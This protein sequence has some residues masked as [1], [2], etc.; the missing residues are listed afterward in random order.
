MGKLTGCG[1]SAY[2]VLALWAATAIALQA[3]T[4][5]TLFDFGGLDGANPYSALVQG[6]GGNLYGTTVGGGAYRV[7]GGGGTIFKITPSGTLTTLYNFCA[8]SGCTDGQGPAAGLVLATN[9]DFYGTTAHGGTNTACQAAYESC[10]TIFEITPAGALTTLYNFCSQGSYPNCTDGWSPVAGLF[11]AANGDL[12]GT[13]EFG[14][15]LCGVNPGYPGCGTVFKITP[16]G[17]LTTLHAFCTQSGCPDGNFPRAGLVQA[18]DGDFYGTTNGGGAN[19]AGTIFKITPGG[20]LT[21]LYSF[22]SLSGCVDGKAPSA[23]LLQATNG[24]FYGTTESGGAN[25]NGTVFELTPSG[26]LTTLY[27]FCALSGCTDGRGPYAGLVQ[28]T[29]GY[30]YGTT[31]G[32]G[33]FSSGTIFKIIPAGSLTTVHDFCQ[34]DRPPRCSAGSDSQAALIQATNGDFYGTTSDGGKFNGEVDGTVFTLSVGLAPFVKAVPHVGQ[35]GQII[36][37]LGTD[38]TG[39]TAITFNGTP[40]AFTVVAP[41]EITATVPAGA[42]TG[43][44][45]VNT[46]GGTLLSA[47]PFTVIP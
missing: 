6:T 14:G 3:Q 18:S 26:T 41:T 19:S 42:T 27:S 43:T 45:Q 11:Q 29:D 23:G 4:F 24:D 47:G 7:G 20:T 31:A 33:A 12:Y 34:I 22:C 28:A 1:T 15:A 25:S 30:F 46:P 32:G 8:L 17:T 5:T 16:G 9:G 35:V 39:T 40:A 2:A 10:G 21:T 13:T 38:L 37:I 44:V 36:R